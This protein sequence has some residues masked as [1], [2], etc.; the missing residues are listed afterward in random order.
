MLHEGDA[1]IVDRINETISVFGPVKYPAIYEYVAGETAE[2][3]ISLAGGF[4]FNAKKDTI[5]I[6][7]YSADGKTLSSSYYSYSQL[8]NEKIILKPQDKI[9][10][11]DIPD[12]YTE[13]LV[14]IDGFVKYPGYYK[15]NE[16][17]TTLSEIIKEAGGFRNN[18]SLI[19]ATLTRS[20]GTVETDPELERLKLIPRSELTDDEYDYLKAK[21]RQRSG[22]V[23]VDFVKLFKSNVKEEEVI[24]RRGDIINV[25]EAK[26]Y[27]ILL[28]QVV[29][30]GNIMYQEGLSV[31]DYIKLAGGY[32]WRALEGDVRVVKAN[33]GEWVDADDIDKL[34]PGDTIWIPENPPAP[35]FWTV[36]KDSLTIIGQVASVVAATVAVIIA[37]R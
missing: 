23:V 36:F 12:Y 6:V 34:D 8:L 32:S 35:R 26:N 11:R 14:R 13:K 22:K 15:I 16:N 25:P 7:R 20:M 29:S 5:E 1:A 19:E 30:P 9:L 18:A 17:Q 28:G 2:Q 3:L 21:S 4:L 37:T 24:L 31:Y 27:V 10:V 33:T